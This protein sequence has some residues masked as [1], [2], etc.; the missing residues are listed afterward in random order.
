MSLGNRS[1]VL[2]KAKMLH[3]PHTPRN[4]LTCAI[5]QVFFNCTIVYILEFIRT[6]CG[7]VPIIQKAETTL[8]QNE[9]LLK[10][11]RKTAKLFSG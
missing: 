8:Q 11:P 4:I 10:Q 3:H 9:A 5:A 6:M 2:M 7:A 1:H